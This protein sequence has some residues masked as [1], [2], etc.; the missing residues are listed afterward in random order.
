MAPPAS[1]TLGWAASWTGESEGCPFRSV[2][3]KLRALQLAVR[4]W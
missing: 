3:S 4:C 2:S 1:A